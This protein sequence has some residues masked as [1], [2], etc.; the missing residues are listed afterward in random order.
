[1]Q[2]SNRTRRIAVP[3][4][5]LS[6]TQA[7]LSRAT[8]N[9][10]NSPFWRRK[11]RGQSIVVIALSMVVL[12]SVVALA[13]DGGSLYTQRR[14]AQN[15]ADSAAIAGTKLFLTQFEGLCSQ[16]PNCSDGSAPQET[17]IRMTI[18]QYAAANGVAANTI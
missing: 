18:E 4:E 17:L 10:D 2:K 16:N 5:A 12:V 1:M 15:A 11:L 3:P 8:R 6:N 14:S 9:R 13:V 7:P